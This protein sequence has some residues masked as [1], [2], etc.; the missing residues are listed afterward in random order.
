M[1]FVAL[2]LPLSLDPCLCLRVWQSP[3]AP[4]AFSFDTYFSW[5]KE[6]DKPSGQPSNWIQSLL[7]FACKHIKEQWCL[8][9]ERCETVPIQVPP[10]LPGLN[11]PLP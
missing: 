9:F 8:G 4:L 5:C 1:P 7:W 2:L 3:L 6:V 10:W 11:Q